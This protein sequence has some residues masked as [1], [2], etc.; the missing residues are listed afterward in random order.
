MASPQKEHGYAP[1]ANELLEAWSR[2]DDF[3]VATRILFWVLR[4]TYGR[5]DR[6]LNGNR[7]ACV[8]TWAGIAT[9]IGASPDVVRHKG[10]ELLRKQLLL[11]DAQGRLGLQKDH[12]LWGTIL[13]NRR[14][15]TVRSPASGPD[16]SGPVRGP[17]RSGSGPIRTKNVV[18][19]RATDSSTDRRDR[20]DPLDTLTPQQVADRADPKRSP[21]G[22][23]DFRRLPYSE[24]ERLLSEW[25][26]YVQDRLSQERSARVA[27]EMGL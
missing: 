16:R 18:R 27:R 15:A 8:Y 4:N 13:P 26:A 3:T 19:A 2:C 12:A 9:A 7:K 24:Q 1:I 5:Y 21:A 10:L 6:A 20:Q 22:H 23:P 11:I 14:T 25:Q 17:Q